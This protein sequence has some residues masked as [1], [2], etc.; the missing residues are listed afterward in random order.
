MAFYFVHL[1]T[2]DFRTWFN[3]PF[4]AYHT[5]DQYFDKVIKAGDLALTVIN[6]FSGSKKI[7]K[8]IIRELIHPGSYKSK[9][10]DMVFDRIFTSRIPTLPKVGAGNFFG[11]HV[12]IIALRDFGA[13]ASYR[14][15]KLM[16]TNAWKILIAA[17][18]RVS[19]MVWF[20]PL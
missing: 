3:Q 1:N 14:I 12:L 10:L 17:L 16:E 9:D 20:S 6:S 7:Y 19:A 11:Q 4:I 13:A 5:V 8:N 18:D 2:N 15:R